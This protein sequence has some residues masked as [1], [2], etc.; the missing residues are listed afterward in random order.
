MRISDW[1]SDVCSSDLVAIP[2]LQLLAHE[3]TQISRQNGVGGVDRLALAHEATDLLRQRPCA[4]L[5]RR[6]IEH[7]A[8]LDRCPGR[9]SGKEEDQEN[10]HP[11][12][13]IHPTRDRKGVGK[14]KR[15]SARFELG[16]RWT[17]KKK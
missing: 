14:G 13:S 3:D 10:K 8:W 5:Q 4:C 6:V 12:P 2:C 1:S 7:L 16:G 9:Q 15:V 11:H 17:L